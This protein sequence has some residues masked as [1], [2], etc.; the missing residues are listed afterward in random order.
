M[1][2]LEAEGFIVFAG[3]MQESS[4]VLFL[5]YA[6]SEDQVRNRLSQDPWQQDGHAHL[7]RLEEIAIRTGA[8]QPRPEPH[9]D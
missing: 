6:E 1:H 5:F 3:L 7:A 9:R 8:P 4:D 2:G